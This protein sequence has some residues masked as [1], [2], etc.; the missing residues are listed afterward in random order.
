MTI[1]KFSRDELESEPHSVRFKDLYPWEAIAE[2][3]FGASLAV[4]EPGGRTM[5]HGHDP[6]ETFVI[7][8]GA[9]TMRIDD[10]LTSV[11]P[12]DVVYLK[13]RCIHDLTNASATEELVFV[14]VFWDAPAGNR[15]T[16]TP[17]LIIP[18]PPTPNGPLHLGHLAGPYVL[19]DTLRRYY[20]ARG[21]DATL[22]CITDEHQ[23]YVSDRAL[24][25]GRDPHELAAEYSDAIAET[26]E[27]FHARPDVVIRP[28]RDAAYRAAIQARFARLKLT[29]RTAKALY[30]EACAL[31]LYDSYV[32]GGC[33]KC[34]ERTYGFACDA[35]CSLVDPVELVD[36]RCD[37]CHAVPAI[38]DATRLELPIAPYLERLADHHRTVQLSPKLRRL[39]AQWL[40]QPTLAAPASQI[41]TWGIP[42][43]LPGFEGQVISP[44]FEVALATSYLRAT[45][46]PDGDVV[47]C[48]GVDNAFLYLIHDPAIALA[49]DPAAKLP[50]AL[51]AN[52]FLLLDDAKMS[53]SRSHALDAKAIL[54]SAPADLIRLYVAKIRPEDTP[55]SSNLQAA[56]MYVNYIA[57][58]W[59]DWLA[60]LGSAIAEEA[61]S[62]APAASNP[63]LAPWSAEQT[64]F[65]AQLRAI[66]ARAR[67]GYED[68][69]LREVALALG[70]LVERA[71]A[72]GAAQHH[73]AGIKSLEA[74]RETGLA[75]ELSAVRTLA[76]L[77]A[78]LMPLVAAQLWAILG[79]R[80]AIEFFDEVSPI[81]PGQQIVTAALTNRTLF[82]AWIPLSPP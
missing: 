8:R 74:Q 44:W 35:C 31:W 33:P 55:T 37:R 1:R 47:C 49:L 30:C 38:R 5:L 56:T 80:G 69:S 67:Q 82:P 18:S 71:H 54:A 72:F 9:G 61:R 77:A 63:S 14:S 66:A 68:M 75:L 64:Q 24:H 3:P 28:T 11:G 17:K 58:S 40:E 23:S 51:A 10:Q 60:R 13:P 21:I 76:I 48:F 46:V 36:A 59:M 19:A 12:G 22:V 41:S 26:F 42:V 34:G 43:G 6:A 81:A 57:R 29:A 25:E 78:P 65:V 73:L 79:Y 52:E 27:K 45:H 7:C 32:V 16:A 4:I 50:I 15:V 2:T 70:E 62:E 39:A 53:T 20:R